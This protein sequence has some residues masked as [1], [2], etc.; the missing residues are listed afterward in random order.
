MSP[1]K[2]HKPRNQ[3]G[4]ATQALAPTCTRLHNL[5]CRHLQ[6]LGC[7]CG[8]CTLPHAAELMLGPICT[9]KRVCTHCS[10]Y[11]GGR[12]DLNHKT[13]NQQGTAMLPAGPTCTKMHN[14][15]CPHSSDRCCWCALRKLLHTSVPEAAPTC[16]M[17]VVP[18][19]YDFR[20]H[21]HARDNHQQLMHML[22]SGC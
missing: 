4:T 21:H 15:L 18:E 1:A 7:W 16:T 5:P 19:K 20:T 14:R 6:V 13:H 11:P 2:I 9:M 12:V 8:L 10:N 22:S 3:L 17:N